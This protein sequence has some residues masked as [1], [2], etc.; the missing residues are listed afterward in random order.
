MRQAGFVRTLY[1]W[2]RHGS[3]KAIR[4][5]FRNGRN[6]SHPF[7]QDLTIQLPC[8]HWRSSAM[9]RSQDFKHA[10]PSPDRDGQNSTPFN[11]VRGLQDL[12]ATNPNPSRA[13]VCC[14]LT[15]GPVY[16]GIPQPPV[17]SN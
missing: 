5:S 3:F 8:F 2:S 11:S 12:F 9:S 1:I 10:N 4:S 14:R 7:R 17:N 16:A 6:L 13:D 15:A